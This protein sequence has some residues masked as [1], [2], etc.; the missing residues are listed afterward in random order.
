METPNPEALPVVTSKADME[1]CPLCL[2]KWALYEEP[3]K[4]GKVFLFCLKDEVSIWIRDPLLGKYFLTQ[5]EPC[6]VCGTL[7]RLFY[8][9]DQYIKMKCPKCGC[10]IENVDNQKHAMLIKQEEMKGLRKTFSAESE[11]PKDIIT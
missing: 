1:H 3:G 5:S 8:R 2:T 10:A 4:E 7:M 6:A 9:S 11:K